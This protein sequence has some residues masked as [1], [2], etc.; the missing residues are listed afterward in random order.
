MIPQE[1]IDNMEEAE[2]FFYAAYREVQR[3]KTQKIISGPLETMDKYRSA[4]AKAAERYY[5]DQMKGNYHII[6]ELHLLD[7][8]EI[9]QSQNEQPKKTRT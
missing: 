8:E 3:F 1:I 4:R 5:M 6:R 2:R 9:K 7:L